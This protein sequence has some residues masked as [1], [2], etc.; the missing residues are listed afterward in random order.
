MSLRR[1]PAGESRKIWKGGTGLALGY[2][3]YQRADV[4][5]AVEEFERA[6]VAAAAAE[7]S[8]TPEIALNIARLAG[9]LGRGELE[10]MEGELADNVKIYMGTP[11]GFQFAKQYAAVL[12]KLGKFDE[13]V[14]AIEQQLQIELSEEI[15]RDEL[16]LIGAL[17]ARNSARQF[18]ILR[19][20]L[21]KT[22]S[23][24]VAEYAIA[25]AG[26]KS[27]D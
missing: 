19:D 18:A 22:S 10:K 26:Q 2:I 23:P 3:A 8:P 13:A 20:V 21:K 7:C 24:G 17:I 4:A 16:R 25:P 12:F 5:K 1:F 6:K 15:D 11:Q 27:R 9:N 14:E